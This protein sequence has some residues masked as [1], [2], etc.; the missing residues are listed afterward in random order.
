[1]MP[2]GKHPSFLKSFSY[3]LQG[4][5]GAIMRERNFKVMLAMGA[6][7][8]V[9]GVIVRLDAVSWV[10]VILMIG[11]VLAGELINT[12]IESVV[13]LA[14]PDIH[15]LAKLAKD[16]SAG[17][18]LVLSAAVAVGGAIIYVRAILTLINA[19]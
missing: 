3:A 4:V 16:L 11:V 18:M 19:G 2:D 1:M 14:C 5:G 9:A 12:A 17:A 8:L 10:I 13:D 6:L 7:A 15:P